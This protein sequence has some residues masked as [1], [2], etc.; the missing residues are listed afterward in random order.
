MLELGKLNT[1]V[2]LRDTSVGMFLGGPD[3]EDT[4]LP[5]RYVPIDKRVGDEMEVFIY[6]DSED[7]P[8]ATTDLPYVMRDEFAALNVKEVNRIGAF[9]DWGLEK[10]LLLPFREQTKRVDRD[11]RVFVK[12][13]LDEVTNR[14]FATMKWK[15]DLSDETPHYYSGEP[16]D[17]IIASV[18]DLGFNAIVDQ[19]YNG[20]LYK[21]EVFKPIRIGDRVKAH[22]KKVRE[23]NKIDLQ[24][25]AAGAAGI[26]P[27]AQFI[28][29][30]LDDNE[31]TLGL[32]DKSDPEEIKRVARMSKK[33]FKKAIGSLYKKKLIELLDAGIKKV[34]ASEEGTS[35]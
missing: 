11:E 22:V 13:A 10:D 12:V 24:L 5:N 6:L 32:H 33:A 28:L 20:L 27:N 21:N 14:L 8:V 25:E 18:T 35:E 4:L 15:K 30:L 9:L 1:M 2:I 16:V 31:G 34:A 19:K 29:D 26:E 3:F 23:D 17:A 7:R